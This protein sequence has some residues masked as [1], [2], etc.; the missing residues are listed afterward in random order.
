MIRIVTMAILALTAT[1]ALTQDARNAGKATW[2]KDYPKVVDGGIEVHGDFSVESGWT[3]KKVTITAAPAK[4]GTLL[5]PTLLDHQNGKW[6]KT[7]AKDKTKVIPAKYPLAEGQW[8]IF[9]QVV[10]EKEGEAPL[11]YLMSLQVGD[12]K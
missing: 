12:G 10:F 11:P 4:G 2:A 9:V 6:G 3:V 8:R 5:T 1:T 7:D